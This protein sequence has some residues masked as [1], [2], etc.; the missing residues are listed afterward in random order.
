MTLA[1]VKRAIESKLR[2]KKAEAQEQASFD[3]IL[4]NLIGASVA[5]VLSNE[6]KYPPIEEVY[7]SLFAEEA[8]KKEEIKLDAK[9][10]LSIARLKQYATFH[11]KKLKEVAKEE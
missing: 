6:A 5:C 3:Y 10:Q 11:N 4:G 7:S 2:V 8:K 1:E 9:T